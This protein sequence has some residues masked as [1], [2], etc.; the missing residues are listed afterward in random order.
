MRCSLTDK[1]K[2]VERYLVVVGFTVGQALAF[3]VTV[4]QE[5]FLTLSTHKMLQTNKQTHGQARVVS[6]AVSRHIITLP[7]GH[8]RVRPQP[9]V[10]L[11]HPNRKQR[12]EMALDLHT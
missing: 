2:T 8:Y 9:D 3:V 1:N 7:L 4:S 5:G 6:T 10:L 12:G 11:L